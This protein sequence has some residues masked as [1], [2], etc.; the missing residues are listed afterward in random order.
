MA[1]RSS[2][3]RYTK[4]PP[5]SPPGIGGTNGYEPVASTTTS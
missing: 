5:H 4:A 3:V 2:I 1:S